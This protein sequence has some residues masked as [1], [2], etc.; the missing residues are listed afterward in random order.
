MELYK[1]PASTFVA[2]FIGSPAMNLMAA[3]IADDGTAVELPGGDRLPLA[4]P[5]RLKGREITLGIRPEHFFLTEE[6]RGLARLKADVVEQLGADTLVHGH[7]G[8]DRKT[9]TARFDGLFS[10]KPGDLLPLSVEP[11]RLHIFDPGS[12]Q[13][14]EV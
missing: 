10:A 8:T 13:R 1:R 12:G 9:L 3:R 6:D 5:A 4:A 14:L 11:A 7:F 2:G